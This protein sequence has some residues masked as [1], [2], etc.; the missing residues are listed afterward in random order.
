MTVGLDLEHFRR[1]LEEERA[2]LV[3]AK[4]TL[5]H[6]GSVADETGDLANGPG[7]HLGDHG[8]D[9][10]QRELDD[11]LEENADHQLAE[12]DAALKRIEDGTYGTCVVCGKPIG[13]ERLEALPWTRYCI[14]DARKQGRG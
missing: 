14:D 8:T 6:A 13:D 12:I 3:G 2:R 7:D 11:G 10:F 5:N 9:T 1:L 4:A